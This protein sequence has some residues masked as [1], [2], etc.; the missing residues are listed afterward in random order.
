MREG[1][2][3]DIGQLEK[4]LRRSGNSLHR[5]MQVHSEALEA[6]D[7]AVTA[8]ESAIVLLRTLSF[9]QSLDTVEA[10]MKPKRRGKKG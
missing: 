7:S 10:S 8:V 4:R 3:V 5:R 9:E 6:L 2:V 1:S